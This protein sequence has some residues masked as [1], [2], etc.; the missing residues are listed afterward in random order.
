MN[1]IHRS[2]LFVFL[3]LI[4]SLVQAEPVKTAPVKTVK[5]V[6][7]N[8]VVT[9]ETTKGAIVIELNPAKAPITVKNFCEYVEGGFYDGLIFHRV[10]P[11][12]MIQGGGMK[13][14]M[15][16]RETKAPIK[17]ESANGLENNR[18]TISMART[19]IPDSATAQFFINLKENRFLNG[20]PDKVGYA[21]FGKVISGIEVV[22]AISLAKTGNRDGH[23]NVPV[24]AIR[25]I[26]ATL[27]KQP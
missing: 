11:D 3:T 4:F 7:A 2:G 25:I 22:D 5:P 13:V 10:I 16:E 9:L 1:I 19:Q 21:V 17:N 27:R 23:A 12:F 8:P 6:S 20:S 14:D 15:G 18:G 26:K 24:D